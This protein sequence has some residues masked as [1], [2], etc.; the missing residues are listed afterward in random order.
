MN[1]S[2]KIEPGLEST[3]ATLVLILATILLL[4]AAFGPHHF[5]VQDNPSETIITGATV[6]IVG[7]WVL[8]AAYLVNSNLDKPEYVR[9]WLEDGTSQM[10]DVRG[11][12]KIQEGLARKV[13]VRFY[14]SLGEPEWLSGDG[15]RQM[16]VMRS[17][18][19][20]KITG[21]DKV[22]A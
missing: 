9:A 20:L 13:K 12:S 3:F 15:F 21:K 6:L 4:L 8:S 14:S 10:A 5:L 7:V 11:A 2:L 1:D 22:S 19:R 17:G 18:T 16:Q